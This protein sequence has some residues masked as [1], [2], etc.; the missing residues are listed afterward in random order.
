LRAKIQ[1]ILGYYRKYVESAIRDAN[2]EHLIQAPDAAE[3]ARMIH[4]YYEGLLTQARIQNDAEV[5]RELQ[6]GV[7]ALLG[8]PQTE[9]IAA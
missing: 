2:A 5:L 6:R 8:L 3:K 9:Q 1:E 4:A 7:F